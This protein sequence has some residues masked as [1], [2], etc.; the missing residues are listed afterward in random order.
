MQLIGYSSAHCSDKMN[1]FK[2]SNLVM[3][4]NVNGI[5]FPTSH[6]F[7]QFDVVPHHMSPRWGEG[8]GME[9]GTLGTLVRRLPKTSL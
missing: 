1:Y 9:G 2:L 8:V 7:L 5:A 3:V 4:F 6:L